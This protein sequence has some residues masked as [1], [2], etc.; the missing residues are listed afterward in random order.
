MTVIVRVHRVLVN[1]LDL[2][3]YL[4][5]VCNVMNVDVNS[6]VLVHM[7]YV[8]STGR[9]SFYLYCAL[10]AMLDAAQTIGSGLIYF[11]T[12]YGMWWV[13]T[14]LLYHSNCY[15]IC[16]LRVCFYSAVGV[17]A[18]PCHFVGCAT[19]LSTMI[20]TII[21]V[22][23][24]V[25]QTRQSLLNGSRYQ[26][27]WLIEYG[28]TSH[29]HIIRHM[30]TGK[31]SA[32]ALHLTMLRCLK[33]LDDKFQSPKFRVSPG[34]SVLKKGTPVIGKN[35]TGTPHSWKNGAR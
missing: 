4:V 23:Q 18:Y 16:I 34:T 2:T 12:I 11:G 6:C 21:S 22:H 5:V 29:Q 27:D 24:S 25:H 28:L 13:T 1:Y 8:S 19:L 30:G 26:H 32:Y 20:A 31:I 33:F 35:V 3:L 7:W 14:D 15:C 17:V 9:K 10:M